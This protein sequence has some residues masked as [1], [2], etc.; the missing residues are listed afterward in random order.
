MAALTPEEVRKLNAEL[1]KQTSSLSGINQKRAEERVLVQQIGNIQAAIAEHTKAAAQG[2]EESREAIVE[3]QG[4]LEKVSKKQEEINKRLKKNTELRKEAVDLARKLGGEM[5]NMYHWLMETDKTIRSTNLQLGLSGTKAAAMRQSFEESAAMVMRLGGSIEDVATIQTTFANETGRAHVLTGEMVK[6]I[7]LIGKGTG[8]GVEQAAKLGAQFEFMGFDAKSTMDYV[9]GVVETSERMGVN[10]TKVLETVSDNFK[11]LSTFT[12]QNGVA[13]FAKMAQDAEATRVSMESALEVAEATRG[14]E[15]V[16][17]LGAELQVMGGEFAKMDPFQWMY[18]ARNEPDKLIDK[19]SEMTTGLYTLKK[20]A[21]G[22]FEKIISPADR[23]RLANVAESLGRTKEEMFEIAQRRFDIVA[24]EKELAGMGLTDREK[25]LIA[26]AAKMNKETGRFQVNLA[27]TMTDIRQLTKA[28]AE[29]FAK[30]QVSLKERAKE[31]MTFDQ[32]LKA[33]INML[34]ASLLPV[35]QKFNEVFLPKMSKV[36]DKF[37]EFAEQ[38]NGWLKIGSRL[39]LAAAALKAGGALLNK[40]FGFLG[41][42]IFGRAGGKAVAG[43][44]ASKTG[45]GAGIPAT[46]KGSSGLALQ[47]AGIGQGAAAKGAGFKALGTGAGVGA[48]MAGAGAGI[49][50]AAKG[51]SELAD[52]MSKLTPE[53]AENLKSIAMTMAISFPAAAAGVALLAGVAAPA[54]GPLLA[55][56]AAVLMV[57][58]A[59]A[60]AAVGIGKMAEGFGSMFE[61]SKGAGDDMMKISGG[62]AGIAASLGAATITLPTAIGLSMVLKRMAKSAPELATVGTSLKNIKEGLTG[63]AEDYERIA[64][65]IKTISGVKLRRNSALEGL[66]DMLSKPLRVEFDRSRVNLENSVTLNIDGQKFMRRV[67]DTE[68]AVQAREDRKNNKG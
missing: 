49:M 22:T 33:T 27:G 36:A 7:E 29:S 23:D 52:S 54:T 46:G 64:D 38:K 9:Q 59:V 5:K 14:L 2:N 41:D 13:S 47:R 35:L 48:A 19:I 55:L 58:G 66:A 20:T 45:L 11:K 42:K 63:S 28:Q 26:G 50:L 57:G 6:N 21:D 37:M 3:L 39:L 53:Q 24:T 65:A 1:A 34:K 15:N 51:L 44:I 61:A 56:G 60:L 68:L 62:L 10:T 43:G 12:F 32:Q 4:E 16:I 25:Q 30:E 18:L 40:G 8:L 67:Y 31:A 17:E